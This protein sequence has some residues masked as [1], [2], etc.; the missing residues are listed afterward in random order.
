[1]T[2]L[3]KSQMQTKKALQ[4]QHSQTGTWLALI[5]RM[6][7]TQHYKFTS[8]FTILACLNLSGCGGT[9]SYTIGD[10]SSDD[11]T[12]GS[13]SS[14]ESF[15]GYY[16]YSVNGC[17]TGKKDYNSRDEL[18]QLLLNHEANSYCAEDMRK[19]RFEKNCAGQ[20]WVAST[21]KV[22][23]PAPT[24]PSQPVHEQEYKITSVNDLNPFS[25]FI[26][27]YTVISSNGDLSIKTVS[28]EKDATLKH[29]VGFYY[30]TG[31]SYTVPLDH[32]NDTV[33][34]GTTVWAETKHYFYGAPNQS[35][36]WRKTL[37]AKRDLSN[38]I[39]R[40]NTSY[41][42]RQLNSTDFEF[43]Q[44]NEQTGSHVGRIHSKVRMTL[45][46]IP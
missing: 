3:A 26:G 12:F 36:R 6:N 5:R 13:Q 41:Q 10:S 17:N 28:I 25:N 39:D 21:P 44:E 4:N 33:R 15:S 42:I 2:N 34:D 45:R 8:I 38:S 43:I 14:S 11:T 20:S 27:R 22:P 40:E 1:M 31:G 46:K 29:R 7:H 16:Q 9:P 24:Q 37:W 18:C 30:E 19:T 35:A 23:A 32:E